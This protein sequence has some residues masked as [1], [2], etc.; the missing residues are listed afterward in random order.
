MTTFK[1]LSAL[2]AL[3][4]VVCVVFAF[5][6]CSLI[7]GPTPD[8][9][10]QE[11]TCADANNDHN[12]DNCGAAL[13]ECADS[14]S[15]H[16]CDVCGKELSIHADENKDHKCD[17]CGATVS[18]C[19]DADSD[20]KCDFCGATASECADGDNDHYC[21]ACNKEL[22][23]CNVDNNKDHKCDICGYKFSDCLDNDKDHVCNHCGGNVGDHADADPAT[24]GHNCN[25]CGANL[26]ADGED[27]GHD[28]DVCGVNLCVDADASCECDICGANLCVDV[29]PIDHYCDVCGKLF[30]ECA[31]GEDG[32]HDCDVCYKSLCAD[33][34]D[35]GCACDVCGASLCV[36]ADNNHACDNCEALLCVDSSDRGHACDVCGKSLCVDGE[37]EDHNCDACGEPVCVD[38]DANLICDTCEAKIAIINVYVEGTNCK[39]NGVLVERFYSDE[40][41]KAV[42]PAYYASEYVID[43]W[44]VYDATGTAIA[45]VENGAAFTPAANGN[46]YIIPVFIA[47][48]L[49]G[50]TNGNLSLDVSDS[51]KVANDVLDPA[52]ANGPISDKIVIATAANKGILGKS[53]N[54]QFYI[55]ADPT[56]AANAVLISVN[57]SNNNG[58]SNAIIEIA[59]DEDDCYG[60]AYVLSFDYFLDYSYCNSGACNYIG[61]KDADGNKVVIANIEQ[62]TQMFKNGNS[63]EA[64]PDAFLFL[65]RTP[66]NKKPTVW[67][68]LASDTWYTFKVVIENNQVSTLWALRGS[69]EF[70]LIDIQDFSSKEISSM[71]ITSVYFE[72]G[73]WNNLSI[74]YFDNLEFDMRH[75]CDDADNSHYC[76]VCEKALCYDGIDAD[77]NCD[78]C[79]ANLCS[80]G[81][82][83]DHYCDCGAK[84]SEC[85]DEDK[86]HYCDIC[87]IGGFGGEC[88]DGEDEGH[89]CDYCG[90]NLCADE[91]KNH[92]C[93]VCEAVLSE[94]AD[95]DKDHKCEYCG[96]TLTECA[97]ENK[98]HTCDICKAEG[99][100][101]HADAAGD[102][103]HLCDYGCGANAS[104]HVDAEPDFVCDEC[105]VALCNDS[106]K[107]HVCDI[108]TEHECVWVVSEHVDADKNH[109]CDFEG[110]AEVM[111]EH[112]DAIDDAD[113]ACDYGCGAII[114]ECADEDKNH[115]CEVCNKF[116]SYCADSNADHKCDVCAKEGICT[117]ADKNTLCDN[118]GKYVAYNFETGSMEDNDIIDIMHSQ[119]AINKP[120]AT[121]DNILSNS[122]TTAPVD[123]AHKYGV[124]Y[125]LSADP[126]NAANQVLH[127]HCQAV[128]GG[129]ANIPAAMLLTPTTVDEGGALLVLQADVYV[130]SCTA[131][132]NAIHLSAIKDSTY[133]LNQGTAPSTGYQRVSI[134]LSNNTL[135]IGGVQTTETM[136]QWIRYL[137]IL[138]TVDN[139]YYVYYS[140]DNGATYTAVKEAAAPSNTSRLGNFADVTRMGIE[141]D[142]YNTSSQ[143]YVDNLS[144]VRI[145]SIDVPVADSVKT[146]D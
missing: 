103:D 69:D 82:I 144:V 95:A 86:T 117:D 2:L 100:G 137:F 97:D 74:C 55:A 33:G 6:S 47:N 43:Y 139:Q 22:S 115:L 80:E 116:V 106:D 1:K 61:V 46:Y 58:G 57:N 12:C 27:E 15:D 98:D 142:T 88:A 73:Y 66:E 112:A 59:L 121:S 24:D 84:L 91:D 114:G 32:N 131:G 44:L 54:H 10:E 64:T 53:K 93:D 85:A 125:S 7:P 136:K 129:G 77:H 118:C 14:D 83:A 145:S 123:P 17:L 8:G 52:W 5:S 67:A 16:N 63:G 126:V 68:S 31:D 102:G 40:E 35:E 96:A 130:D 20:H 94:C 13:S 104:E 65:G 90:K 146:I 107:N 25:Y 138:D 72:A 39:V 41:I 30:S 38:T 34:E 135:K 110:C 51:D 92:A 132:K 105:A 141:N 89:D 70:T 19:E 62:R 124:H 28:C 9:G 111:G 108:T 50:V 56:N 120:T 45:V 3:I 127:V 87:G 42:I 133:V 122:I 81:D 140:L 99:M 21:D 78:R 79:D 128:G 29:A 119:S 49:S 26:C 11:H 134:A 76:D 4:L 143:S 109:D 37:D 48:N 23:S 36:D 71:N 101:E 18:E 113:H 60:D 75:D